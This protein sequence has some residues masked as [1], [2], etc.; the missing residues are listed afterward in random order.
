MRMGVKV[1]VLGSVLACLV[2]VSAYAQQKADANDTSLGEIARELKAQKAKEAKPVMVITND[3][4]P[5]AKNG[6][7]EFGG[8]SPEKSSAA[9]PA[10][11]PAAPTPAHDAEY[12]RAR[13]ST[14]QNQLDL[15]KRE[16]EVLQQKFG[17]T[18]MQ[19]YADPSKTLQQEYS[20]DDI[21]KLTADVDAKKQQIADDE[22][23][24]DDLREQ[25]RR[26]NG[27]PGWLR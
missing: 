16:L 9:A 2:G 11:G 8:S 10:E 13:Q 22:K 14:L 7:P 25:L 26:E 21:N 23:A 27:D 5:A 12:Y 17:Q 4:I 18:Q 1:F 19:N 3:N 20:R 15:H 24:L 6:E